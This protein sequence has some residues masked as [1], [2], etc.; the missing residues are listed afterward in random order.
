MF[1][2]SYKD[3]IN[4]ACLAIWIG[5][6]KPLTIFFSCPRHFMGFFI[7]LIKNRQWFKKFP[8]QKFSLLEDESAGNGKGFP[9]FSKMKP[10]SCNK[11][12]DP[13]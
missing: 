2:K 11:G 9:Y 6:P 12:L 5:L 10:C 13:I 7:V 1:S 8:N 4:V 3:F